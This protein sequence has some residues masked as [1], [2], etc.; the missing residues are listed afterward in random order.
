MPRSDLW[1]PR[2][3][4]GLP[5]VRSGG[6]YE[7]QQQSF[8]ELLSVLGLAMAAVFTVLVL[9]FTGAGWLY[10]PTRGELEAAAEKL[11]STR[12]TLEGGRYKGTAPDGSRVDQDRGDLADPEGVRGADGHGRALRQIRAKAAG[13]PSINLNTSADSPKPR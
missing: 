10:Y 11:R 13:M 1:T 4:T 6:Q 12:G 2:P 7:A 8:K 9:Q 3:A 5:V